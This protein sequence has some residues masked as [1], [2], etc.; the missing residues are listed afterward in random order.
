MGPPPWGCTPGRLTSGVVRTA[1]KSLADAG[2]YTYF[3]PPYSPKLD[4]IEPVFRQMKHQAIPIRGSATRS[5]LRTA[6]VFAHIA[7]PIRMEIDDDDDP[8]ALDV[9]GARGAA[10][11]ARG[12]P[13][14]L[15]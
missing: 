6:V 12:G 11:L 13:G 1:R 5:G 10:I 2:V 14:C 15:P 4:R 3:M 7:G 9:H 8:A